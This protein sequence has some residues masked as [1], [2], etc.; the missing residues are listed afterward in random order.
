M[1]YLFIYQT[2][3][4]APLRN[5]TLRPYLSSTYPN[6]MNSSNAT[7]SSGPSSSDSVSQQSPPLRKDSNNMNSEY[8]KDRNVFV[9]TGKKSVS[10]GSNQKN[11]AGTARDSAKSRGSTNAADNGANRKSHSPSSKRKY[12]VNDYRSYDDDDGMSDNDDG[13]RHAPQQQHRQTNVESFASKS[14]SSHLPSWLPHNIHIEVDN[15]R[16]AKRQIAYQNAK[17]DTHKSNDDNDDND[18]G[19]D[20]DDDGATDVQPNESGR[21]GDPNLSTHLNRNNDKTKTQTFINELDH[22]SSSSSSG[23]TAP[24]I[25]TTTKATATATVNHKKSHSNAIN[26]GWPK[27]AFLQQSHQQQHHHQQRYSVD[28]RANNHHNN[29]HGNTFDGPAPSVMELE[30]VAGYDGGL[31]QYFILEA[32]DS[33]TRKLRLNVSSIYAD[34]PL[35]RIDLAGNMNVV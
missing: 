16:I 29:V 3:K 4:P 7:T 33:R 13:I 14:I 8:V 22:G 5:C 30:C 10:N 18:D 20:D 32:Y 1:Y 25:M 11:V 23:A 35:F 17:H 19:D 31:P 6:S 21:S 12:L 9:T 27:A 34:V 24:A 2:A 28:T 15:K 26:Y